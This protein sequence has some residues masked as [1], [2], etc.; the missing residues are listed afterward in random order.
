M[1]KGALQEWLLYRLESLLSDEEIFQ[2]QDK[3]YYREICQSITGLDLIISGS[4]KK[5]YPFWNYPVTAVDK[6]YTEL[7]LKSRID[8]HIKYSWDN[9]PKFHEIPDVVKSIVNGH[10]DETIL[11]AA[12]TTAE[13]NRIPTGSL[14]A[15]M[16]NFSS[17][18]FFS[19]NPYFTSYIPDDS[20]I[21]KLGEFAAACDIYMNILKFKQEHPWMDAL[22]HFL[23]NL[24]NP[25]LEFRELLNLLNLYLRYEGP[26]P[27]EA[28]QREKARLRK[29]KQREKT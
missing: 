28:N 18:T 19:A 7:Q 20:T 11:G 3:G 12:I 8:Q 21:D 27:Q 15:S 10:T 16:L 23:F 22:R 26:S 1:A 24:A 14:L 13:G 29:Q 25:N 5:D 9:V 2:K 4:R 6:Y 17:D